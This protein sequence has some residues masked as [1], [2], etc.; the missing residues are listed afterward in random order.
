VTPIFA[1]CVLLLAVAQVAL[2][3][4]LK[5]VPLLVAVCHL[6]NSSIIGGA[7]FSTARLL[8]GLGVLSAVLS[9]KLQWSLKHSVD[10]LMVLFAGVA[11]ITSFGHAK[12]EESNPLVFSL[13][14]IY[15]FVGAYVYVRTYIPS[16]KVFPLV[17]KW[18]TLI[19]LPLALLMAFQKITE[20]NPY[21]VLGGGIGDASFLREG[22]VRAQGPFGHP[23]LAG[24][25]AA[26]AA[27]LILILW[28]Q[29][30]RLAVSGLAACVL[31]TLSSASSGPIMTFTAA[32]GAVLLWKVRFH[33]KSIK[34]AALLALIVLHFTMKAPVWYLMARIDLTGSSTGWHRAELITAAL[35]H[36][37]EWWLS[38]TDY[39][40]HW[41]PTGVSWS[42][43]HTDIT[44]HYLQMGVVGGLPLM[45]SFILIIAICFR[46]LGRNLNAF[47]NTSFEFVFW[48]IGAMLSAHCFTF[49]SVAYFDQSNFWI[50]YALGM[51]AGNLTETEEQNVSA[52]QEDRSIGAESAS[53]C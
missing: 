6:P 4:R 46:C 30:R 8:I 35:K 9:G 2:P 19:L 42:P 38:G 28:N 45:C 39:T 5:F 11:I 25:V 20:R 50:A 31:I 18:V 32:A 34:R 51:S 13:G 10:R 29:N 36:L 37:E 48:C 21:S 49:L 44:N 43:N 7:D 16:V 17:A 1:L 12:T 52:M 23:I 26:S 3:V 27:P 22:K 24:T 41:M 33:L 47:G 40:V 14:L 15:N 53:A